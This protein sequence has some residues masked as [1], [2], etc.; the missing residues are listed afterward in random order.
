MSTSSANIGWRLQV[1]TGFFTPLQVIAVGLRFYSRWL[2][3]GQ[4]HPLEDAL[5]VVSLISQLILG[6]VGVASVTYAGVG[7]HLGYLEEHEPEKVLNWGKYLL[8]LATLYF[9][10]VNIPKLAVLALYRRLF[11]QRVARITVYT[12]AGILIAGSIANT[13]VSLAACK[14]FEANYN[15]TLP[16]AKCIDK[17]SFFV[18]TSVPN[19]ATDVVMLALPLP[20]VW[21]LHNTKRIKIALTF[22]FLVGSLGLVASILRFHTFFVTNSFTDGTYDAVELIIWTVAEPGIYLISACLLTYRP[23]LERVG[24]S[25]LFGSFRTSVKS[26]NPSGYGTG[27]RNG[28]ADGG[29][30]PLRNVKKMGHGF[31]EL[32]ED[33][34][35]SSGNVHILRASSERHVPSSQGQGAGGITVTTEIQNSWGAK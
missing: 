9:V 13:I 5:V 8:V 18:W 32:D 4:S 11:P 7:Q 15:P 6:G 16:G 22:T 31:T 12:I 26:S 10:D 24:R 3:V 19:I 28:A 27:Q 21:S 25:R 34:D 35:A 20:I 30:V 23:L 33:D 14:P 29:A 1:F 17:E 2:V